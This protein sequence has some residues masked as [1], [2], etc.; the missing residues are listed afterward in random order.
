MSYRELASWMRWRSFYA[1]LL[2]HSD[3]FTEEGLERAIG[4]FCRREEM[5]REVFDSFAEEQEI[6]AK[7]AMA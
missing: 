4:D 5:D 6:I 1:G 2:T 7:A 3:E